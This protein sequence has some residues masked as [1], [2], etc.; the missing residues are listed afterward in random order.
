M[1]VALLTGGGDCPGLNAVIRAA[2]RKGERRYGDELLGFRDGWKGPIED[3]TMSLDVHEMRGSLPR[4]GTVLGSSRTNPYKVEGG[5]E[6]VKATLARNGVDALIAIGGEDTLGVA[7]R[8]YDEGVS[9]VGVPEELVAPITTT[10]EAG[11][12]APTR[13]REIWF[14]SDDMLRSTPREVEVRAGIAGA[15]EAVLAGPSPQEQTASL[16]TSIPAGTELLEVR[17]AEDSG[18][19]T[20]DLTDELQLQEGSEL[21]NAVAQLVYT[22]TSFNDTS[23]QVRFQIDGQVVSVPADEGATASVVTR[24]DY[25][26][27]DPAVADGP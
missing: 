8:L 19:L 17:Q 10:T 5:P 9:V 23:D 22:A 14:L 2:V 7:A 1:K 25:A 4:G 15:I 12:D 3:V 24:A 6:A 11:S 21:R 13:T 26:D 18:L 16:T 20:I 27:L